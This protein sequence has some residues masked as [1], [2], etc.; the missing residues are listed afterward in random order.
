M[1]TDLNILLPEND[2][3]LALAR[4]IGV[5]L[6]TQQNTPDSNDP[7]EG[8]LHR[9]NR[10]RKAE[11]TVIHVD[12]SALWAKIEQS[13][14]V[15]EPEKAVPVPPAVNTAAPVFRL[16]WAYAASAA[17]AIL[18]V[19]FF[20]YVY[21][22]SESVYGPFPENR[23]I[24]LADAS[25][26]T[27]RRN[28]IARVSSSLFSRRTDVSLS[29]E[30]RF[31]VT[32]DKNRAFVVV[33]AGTEI[34]VTGTTFFVQELADGVSVFLEEGGINLRVPGAETVTLKPGEHAIG[35]RNVSVTKVST[36]SPEMYSDW[37]TDRLVFSQQPLALVLRDVELHFKIRFDLDT[38]LLEEPLTGELDLV[39][40]QQTLR[41]L[42]QAL[43]GRF[44][45]HGAVYRFIPD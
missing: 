38:K 20:S 39:S 1:S 44:E 16:H 14:P 10:R 5:F 43:G 6:E 42:G 9:W 4:R 40:E 35:R 19:F 31:H 45:L 37:L 13:L 7:L 22:F 28:S 12:S 2:P 32:K 33:T 23:T 8:L 15:D 18:M 3:D 17:A 34:E 41:D 36:P 30:A 11:E 21:F 24:T 25:E 26:I 27:L 29:G